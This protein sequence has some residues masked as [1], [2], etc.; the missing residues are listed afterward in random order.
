MMFAFGIFSL[1]KL[2]L[3]SVLVLCIR[4][5]STTVSCIDNSSSV[6][7]EQATFLNLTKEGKK[8]IYM[9]LTF[10]PS[11]SAEFIQREKDRK[12]VWVA[13]GYEYV[14]RYPEN[15]DVFSFGLLGAKQ[16]S[17]K[18][19]I[20][21]GN[22]SETC[23]SRFDD[24]L[25]DY[26]SHILW[27]NIT[28][29]ST[30]FN[31]SN[32][33]ICHSIIDDDYIRDYI[34]DI[35]A[36]KIGYNFM[37]YMENNKKVPL[38]KSH[39]N[40]IV[41]FIVLFVYSFFPFFI[42]M[43]FYIEDR[44]RNDG[45]FF[46]SESPYGPSVILTRILFSGN[47]KNIAILRIT[48]LLILL[49]CGGYLV[50]ECVYNSCQCS[51]KSSNRNTSFLDAEHFYESRKGDS[52]SEIKKYRTV[53]FRFCCIKNVNELAEDNKSGENEKR[54]NSDEGNSTYDLVDET[55]PMELR[56]DEENKLFQDE[57]ILKELYSDEEN[58][59]FQDET[60]L[61]ESYSDEENKTFQD[62]TIPIELYNDEENKVF[63]KVKFVGGTDETKV[64]EVQNKDDDDSKDDD[65]S[66]SD[67]NFAEDK[68]AKIQE[69]THL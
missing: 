14:F 2:K 37:C 46:G 21:I 47:S 50:K 58:K 23:E 41:V 67:G 10:N 59:T 26:I 31:L 38:G 69:E 43:A 51:L 40:G 45:Y 5:V 8:V 61:K 60:I 27:K 56:G 12:W 32:G 68:D 19:Q 25:A 44:K 17:I 52:K 33:Y 1:A 34:S 18:V 28:F 24:F 9:D 36:V 4:L 30:V 64:K 53:K 55:I 11:I 39:M 54:K 15:V 20:S 13:K 42:E 63:Q 49:S 35:S 65:S 22:V 3:I 62:E 57:T 16:D 7:Y 66:K 29:P 6:D 48:L